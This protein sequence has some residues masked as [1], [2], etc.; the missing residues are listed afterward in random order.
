[1]CA[2]ARPS[3]ARRA[4]F[5]RRSQQRRRRPGAPQARTWA[6]WWRSSAGSRTAHD[7]GTTRPAGPGTRPG[8]EPGT[9]RPAPAGAAGRCESANLSQRLAINLLHS[10][11]ERF[12]GTVRSGESVPVAHP[13]G[14]RN[15]LP[16]RSHSES[17]VRTGFVVVAAGLSSM[18][19]SAPTLLPT[20]RTWC[21]L[22]S[23]RST[24]WRR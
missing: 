15:Q 13:E 14:V 16:M 18:S 5:A 8:L 1:M 17:E 20:I 7:A 6:R 4:F 21:S 19:W 24:R 11:R 10:Q 12:S 2:L 23:T 22:T 3:A 9:L